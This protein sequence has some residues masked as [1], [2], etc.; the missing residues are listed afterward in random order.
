VHIH[1]E[2]KSVAIKLKRTINIVHD[3]SDGCHCVSPCSPHAGTPACRTVL[4]CEW[5]QL[6]NR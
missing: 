3:V 2:P 5:G 4:S 1:L 6:D